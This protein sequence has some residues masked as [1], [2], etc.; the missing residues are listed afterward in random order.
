MHDIE[1][2]YSWRDYYIASED[3]LSPFYRR[4]YSEFSFHNKVYNYYIHPQWDSFGS[5]TLYCKVI[6][7]G[8]EKEIAVIEMLGEW[9]DTLHNDIMI[10]KEEVIDPLMNEGISKFILI[11]ENVMNF[12]AS[13]ESYYELWQEEVRDMD[14]WILCLN[15]HKHVVD[16][17]RRY[18]LHHYMD[19]P[20][21]LEETE[22]RKI[23]PVYIHKIAEEWLQKRL[24][25]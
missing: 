3:K 16:E 11:G 15:F 2:F 7:V 25:S 22:W 19:I 18:R 17:M 13:D 9:N 12:H 24:D 20:L 21:E 14:G 6:Y 8:Y 10:F 4:K 5:S 1:P 23:K